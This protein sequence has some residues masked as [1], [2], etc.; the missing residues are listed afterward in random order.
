MEQSSNESENI[1]LKYVKVVG[2]GKGS[3]F[4]PGTTKLLGDFWE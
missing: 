4:E 2:F 3:S 1:V